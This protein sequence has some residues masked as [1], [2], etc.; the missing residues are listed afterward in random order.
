MSL[1]YICIV[2]ALKHWNNR[3]SPSTQNVS[4]DDLYP[5]YPHTP[6]CEEHLKA[7][8]LTDLLQQRFENGQTV[9]P[10]QGSYVHNTLKEGTM[11]L[12]VSLKEKGEIFNN[13]IGGTL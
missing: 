10:Q 13:N 9:M 12:P 1:L 5:L 7:C 2:H 3:S 6:L 4:P 11:E 8:T